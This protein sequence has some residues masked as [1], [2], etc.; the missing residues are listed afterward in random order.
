MRNMQNV[1][2]NLTIDFITTT[3]LHYLY[4]GSSILGILHYLYST[5]HVLFAYT[6][7]HVDYKTD[8]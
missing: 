8:R 1:L 3:T 2:F 5:I 7:V 6:V 4:V